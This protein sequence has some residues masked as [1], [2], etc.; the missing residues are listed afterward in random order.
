VNGLIGKTVKLIVKGKVQGVFFRATVHRKAVELGLVGYAK[1]LENGDVEVV[2]QGT[3]AQVEDLLAF[4]R[5]SPGASRVEN[6]CILA[7]ESSGRFASF[8]IKH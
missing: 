2:A 3:G 5:S 7:L 4:I 1:N 6:V 8:G